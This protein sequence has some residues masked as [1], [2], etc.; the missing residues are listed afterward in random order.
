MTPAAVHEAIPADPEAGLTSCVVCKEPVRTVPGGHG[1]TW[2]HQI[3]TV[4]TPVAPAE[5]KAPRE[6]R[7]VIA[8]GLI[9]FGLWV[10]VSIIQANARLEEKMDNLENVRNGRAPLVAQQ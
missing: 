6:I 7:L 10:I 2:D 9:I 3:V 4:A 1:R 8:V 5:P